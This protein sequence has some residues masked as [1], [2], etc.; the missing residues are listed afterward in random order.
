MHYQLLATDLD[1]TFLN[2]QSKVSTVNAQ[3][4]LD[5][6][7]NGLRCIAITARSAKSTI[8]ISREGNLGPLAVCANG[9]IGVNVDSEELIWHDIIAPATAQAVVTA[10]RLLLPG[11]LFASEYD[12][13][14]VHETGFL[15][16]ESVVESFRETGDIVGSLDRGATKLICRHPNYHHLDLIPVI[17]EA[18]SGSLSTSPG[19]IDWMEILPLGISKASGL[20]RACDYLGL[21]IKQAVVIGD[22]LNDLPMF[23]AAGLA[24]AV[25]NAHPSTLEKADLVVSSN[26]DNAVADLLGQLKIEA[27]SLTDLHVHRRH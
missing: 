11:V 1:G 18:S 22:H 20:A 25:A 10:L 15:R 8:R 3:A 7:H 19:S 13:D 5:A 23:E 9:A 16:G 26:D 17:D 2:S 12:R 14:F 24:A 6:Q 27:A 21:N 4:V